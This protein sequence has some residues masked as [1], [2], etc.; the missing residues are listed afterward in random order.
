MTHARHWL[1]IV[2]LAALAAG[3]GF[4]VRH[5]ASPPPGGSAEAFFAQSFADLDGRPAAMARWRGE[6]VVVNF[7]ATW[8]PPCVEEMPDLQRV[9]EDY[10][11]RGVTVIGLGIDSPTLLRRFRDEHRLTMPLFAAG[12][13]GTEVGRA[14]GNGSGALPYTVLV[15]RD[16]RVVR[17]RLGQIKPAELRGWL[18]AQLGSKAG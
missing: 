1:V 17:A 4:A 3:L 13:A 14:L 18:D 15:G 7:W 11:A 12:A 2:A 10:A 6:L 5:F 8:C 16:G 9:H